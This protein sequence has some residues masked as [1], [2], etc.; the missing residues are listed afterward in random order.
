M[1]DRVGHHQAITIKRAG[2]RERKSPEERLGGTAPV[3]QGGPTAGEDWLKA[4]SRDPATQ[5]RYC[6]F[7][8]ALVS[9][10]FS[11]WRGLKLIEVSK[12]TA[13]LYP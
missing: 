10:Y 4:T 6:S 12:R 13:A 1:S 7:R 11:Y 9:L 8:E 2:G 3:P 5:I